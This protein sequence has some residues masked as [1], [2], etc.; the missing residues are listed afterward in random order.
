M[1]PEFDANGVLISVYG[2]I[3]GH[4]YRKILRRFLADESIKYIQKNMQSP[5]TP[6]IHLTCECGA[7]KCGHLAHSSWCPKYKG[8]E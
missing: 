2:Y 4:G 1:R 6:T 8:K 3:P 7:D 5:T